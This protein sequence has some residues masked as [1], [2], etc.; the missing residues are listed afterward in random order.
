[1]HR[2][3]SLSIGVG[4]QR[5]SANLDITRSSIKVEVKV[6]NLPKLCKLVRDVLLRRLFVNVGYKDDPALDS[7]INGI[8]SKVEREPDTSTM[9]YSQRAALVSESLTCVVSTRS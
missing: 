5:S 9:R 1:M 2:V 4:A 3:I 6:F 8:N 7:Y